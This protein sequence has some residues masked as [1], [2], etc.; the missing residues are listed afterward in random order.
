MMQ[1]F[2]KIE[3]ETFY[4]Y[5]NDEIVKIDMMKVR[6]ENT[7]KSFADNSETKV[8]MLHHLLNEHMSTHP[9]MKIVKF[10]QMGNSMEYKA[11]EF[12]QFLKMLTKFE[13]SVKTPIRTTSASFF[14]TLFQSL[15]FV[16]GES[17]VLMKKVVSDINKSTQ[18]P[19]NDE[20]R[21]LNNTQTF[22]IH[23]LIGIMD[24]SFKEHFTSYENFMSYI[25]VLYDFKGSVDGKLSRNHPKINLFRLNLFSVSKTVSFQRVFHLTFTHEAD[26]NGK[27]TTHCTKHEY[28]KN[29]DHAGNKSLCSGDISSCKDID[30]SLLRID[31][32]ESDDVLYKGLEICKS[33]NGKNC[34]RKGNFEKADETLVRE[35][36]F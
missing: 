21:Y 20:L 13:N 11:P 9:D 6:Y 29:F 27:C 3:D 2:D 5:L 23:N 8:N 34:R 33:S 15:M 7:I 19:M 10:A 30:G 14:V 31:Y 28:I 36:F 4:R 17:N 32:S 25:D 24:N 35:L 16:I 18:K 1:F 22:N 12:K 26:I